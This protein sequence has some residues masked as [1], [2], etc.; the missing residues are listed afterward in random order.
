MILETSNNSTIERQIYNVLRKHFLEQRPITWKPIKVELVVNTQLTDDFFSKYLIIFLV[1]RNRSLI[2]LFLF[3]IRIKKRK[4][5]I[6][7]SY[8]HFLT[9]IWLDYYYHRRQKPYM[10][11]VIYHFKNNLRI[12]HFI[13]LFKYYISLLIIIGFFLCLYICTRNIE[14][15]IYFC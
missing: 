14:Q 12:F 1:F 13:S 11:Y 10:H 6:S 4:V 8:F 2:N 9:S 15:M 7:R 5:N 3:Y